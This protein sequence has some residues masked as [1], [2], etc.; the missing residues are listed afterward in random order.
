MAGCVYRLLKRYTLVLPVRQQRWVPKGILDNLPPGFQLSD[1]ATLMISRF[2]FA[3]E[4]YDAQAEPL[5]FPLLSP[6][7]CHVLVAAAAVAVWWGLMA[8]NREVNSLFLSS[9]PV[10]MEIASTIQIFSIRDQYFDYQTVL[11]LFHCYI[12]RDTKFLLYYLKVW[13]Q[14]G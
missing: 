7:F 1:H 12:L 10:N 6:L 4:F 5:F 11:Y 9:K 13:G 8:L 2:C 14:H 3:Y